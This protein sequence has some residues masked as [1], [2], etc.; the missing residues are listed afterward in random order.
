MFRA[1][2]DRSPAARALALVRQLAHLL[3]LP[4][5]VARFYVRALRAARRGGDRWSLDVA[6]RPRELAAILSAASGRR[7]VVEVGT[8]TAWTTVALALSDGR[9]RIT[10]IDPVARGER[11]RY[12]ELAGVARARIEL[13]TGD[14]ADPP[15]ATDGG[16]DFLFVDGSHEREAT[17]AAFEA[18]LPAL[19]PDAVAVFHD[20]GDPAYPGVAEAVA[21]L[22][23]R[24]RV[25]GRCFVWRRGI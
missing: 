13:R 23:L 15:G 25:D 10:S 18:W 6:T 11:E 21:E 19:A 12:L 9:R 20:Y 4:A 2:D 14:G 5:P 17:R 1:D 3:R 24:G 8:G 16:V 22:G 7:R